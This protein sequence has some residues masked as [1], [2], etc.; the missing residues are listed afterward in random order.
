MSKLSPLGTT[1]LT[2]TTVALSACTRLD[3]T[4][5]QDLETQSE[6]VIMEVNTIFESSVLTLQPGEAIG[7][8]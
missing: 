3:S 7:R 4:G 8:L 6:D 2:S 5:I 1:L